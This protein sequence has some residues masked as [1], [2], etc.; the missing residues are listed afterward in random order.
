ML[1]LDDAT[2]LRR[3]AGRDTQAFGVLYDRLAPMVMLRLRGRCADR[4]VVA[5]VLQETFLAVW[6]A[7]GQ[8]DG[9]GDVA[10]WVW[11]IAVRIDPR[12]SAA[13]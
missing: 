13:A 10:G 3:A 9:R 2:L 6:R 1:G 5:D 4:D 12:C 7:A 11:T 8:W